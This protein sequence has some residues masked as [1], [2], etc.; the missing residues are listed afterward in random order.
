MTAG[1]TLGALAAL[2]REAGSPWI[3]AETE[4]LT[5]RLGE[6]RFYVVCVGQFK[7]GKSTLLNALVSASVLPTGVVPVTAAVTVIR[8]GPRLAARVRFRDRDWED[9]DPASL[10]TYVSEDHNP[11]NEKDVTGVEVFVPSPLLRSYTGT[12]RRSRYS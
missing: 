12:F 9:C 3:A 7:R 8:W 4:R 2:A 10:A 5:E 11:G 6:G 1:G